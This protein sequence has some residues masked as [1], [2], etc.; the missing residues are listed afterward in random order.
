MRVPDKADAHAIHH[1]IA[2]SPPL[3]LNSVYTYLLLGEHFSRTCVLAQAGDRAQGFV[4]AYVPPAR[5]DVLF[6]WQ[7]AV[8]RRA[9]GKGLGRLMLQELLERANLNTVR[10]IETTV[11][12]DN[13]ASRRM[14]TKLA[15]AL[16]APIRETPLFGRRLFGPQGHDDEPLLRIGPFGAL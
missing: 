15:R 4:S 9:R 6:I 3:D 2:E 10:Y 7:V 12:P 11:G 5:P 8:H 16:R 14:F 13:L 1:L